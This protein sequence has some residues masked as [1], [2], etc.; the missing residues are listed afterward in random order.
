MRKKSS[1]IVILLCI[2]TLLFPTYVFAVTG[3]SVGSGR[4]AVGN[5][6]DYFV[7]G[8]VYYNLNGTT[9]L[10]VYSLSLW[11]SNSDGCY[12]VNQVSFVVQDGLGTK[13]TGWPAARPMN[14][15]SGGNSA[16][17]EED[18]A[19]QCRAYGGDTTFVKNGYGTDKFVYT[20]MSVACSMGGSLAG[21]DT[22]WFPSSKEWYFHK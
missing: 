2:S 15:I 16:R 19:A 5:Y 3:E 6:I 8:T 4:N 21:L 12:D 14:A 18:W 1:L 17:I 9:Q 7:S 13:I 10:N 22:F 11:V 20:D